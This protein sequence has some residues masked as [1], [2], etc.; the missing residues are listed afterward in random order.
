MI[1]NWL[2]SLAN[3]VVSTFSSVFG[4]EKE[5]GSNESDQTRNSRKRNLSMSS[6]DI[7]I[8]S[9]TNPDITEYLKLDKS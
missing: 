1:S 6:S 2:G 7:S 9:S 8:T 3:K 5:S 4:G